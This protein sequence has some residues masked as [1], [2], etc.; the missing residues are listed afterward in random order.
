MRASSGVWPTTF[1]PA[2]IHDHVLGDS[3]LPTQPRNENLDS[4]PSAPR[5]VRG[6]DAA[7]RTSWLYAY[8]ASSS[9]AWIRRRND[10]LF[11][12]AVWRSMKAENFAWCRVSL[13]DSSISFSSSCF[14]SRLPSWFVGTAASSRTDG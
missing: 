6:V 8:P 9:I 10:R 1:T 2:N 13:Y 4:A 5:R 14:A 3:S 12:A 11:A 7:T